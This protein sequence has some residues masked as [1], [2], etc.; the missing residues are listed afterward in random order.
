M[1]SVWNPYGF[2]MAVN[3]GRTAQRVFMYSMSAAFSSGGRAVP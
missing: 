1:E 2:H 3:A